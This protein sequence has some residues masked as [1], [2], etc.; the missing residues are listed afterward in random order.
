MKLRNPNF[1]HF[2]VMRSLSL[3]QESIREQKLGLMIKNMRKSLQ[4]PQLDRKILLLSTIGGLGRRGST[5]FAELLQTLPGF[6]VRLVNCRRFGDMD[7]R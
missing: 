2:F 5:A 3:F 6:R 4:K 7:G 1:V